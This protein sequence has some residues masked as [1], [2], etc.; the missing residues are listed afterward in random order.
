M[1]ARITEGT[2]VR[3]TLRA[4]LWRVV[5]FVPSRDSHSAIPIVDAEITPVG[6]PRW[7]ERNRQARLSELVAEPV[8]LEDFPCSPC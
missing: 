7:S 3:W 2:I 8:D 5:R 4:G 6:E 1:T